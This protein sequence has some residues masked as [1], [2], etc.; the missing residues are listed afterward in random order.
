[1]LTVCKTEIGG[2]FFVLETEL[3]DKVLGWSR[4]PSMISV[5]IGRRQR[6]LHPKYVSA[7]PGVSSPAVVVSNSFF[8]MLALPV[9]LQKMLISQSN[10]N[11]ISFDLELCLTLRQLWL[12]PRQRIP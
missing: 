5:L 10:R 11:R 9:G 4:T 1:M 3:M 2:F 12:R 7:G 8:A 6:D